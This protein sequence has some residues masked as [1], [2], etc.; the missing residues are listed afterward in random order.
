[1]KWQLQLPDQTSGPARH[2]GGITTVAHKSHEN[3][4]GKTT[5]IFLLSAE[6][7][8]SFPAL[9]HTYA[10]EQLITQNSRAR[11]AQAWTK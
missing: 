6:P 8:F 7:W 4:R 9:S 5:V 11:A 2:V 3:T 10:Q 1:M